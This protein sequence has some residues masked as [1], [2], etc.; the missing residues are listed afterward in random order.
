M[1]NYISFVNDHSG[2]TA[3]TKSPIP[4]KPRFIYFETRDEARRH[5]N[6]HPKLMQSDI[7]NQGKNAPKG[8]RWAV[9]NV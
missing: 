5:V 3:P 8:K 1:K 7:V 2:S 4:V 6:N 9:P